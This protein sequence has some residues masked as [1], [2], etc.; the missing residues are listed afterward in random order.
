MK[1]LCLCYYDVQRFR[2]LSSSQKDELGAACAP[3][4]EALRA[5]GNLLLQASLS[6]PDTWFHFVPSRSGP[7]FHDGP[8]PDGKDQIGAFLVIEADSDEEARQVASR[9]A[10]ANYGG[11]LGF[12]ID[13]RAC[14][15]FEIYGSL[16]I[17]GA[18]ARD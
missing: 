4:D 17:A 14:E 3:H 7:Q 2:D 11:H 9:H 10:T 15:A 1:Y 13:V 5:T 8:Y 16:A 12:A 18:S 6:M